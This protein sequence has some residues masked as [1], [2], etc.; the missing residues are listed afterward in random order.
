MLSCNGYQQSSLID[1][2][3]TEWWFNPIPEGHV[4]R[5]KKAIYGTKQAARRWHMRISTW[6]KTGIQR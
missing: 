5:L 2:K 4:L 3:L 1:V 6:K